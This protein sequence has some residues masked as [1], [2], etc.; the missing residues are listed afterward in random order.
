[1]KNL[2]LTYDSEMV[3]S[4]ATAR[5]PKREF[6]R[7]LINMSPRASRI[8]KGSKMIKITSFEGSRASLLGP[9]VHEPSG[10]VVY[11]CIH[12]GVISVGG[13]V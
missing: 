12:C 8:Q 2:S 3:I 6:D 9:I 7:M 5:L 1:M 13:V 11:I 10:A 4:W